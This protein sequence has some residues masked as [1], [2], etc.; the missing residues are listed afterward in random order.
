M[1]CSSSTRARATTSSSSAPRHVQWPRSFRLQCLA[2]GQGHHIFNASPT[3]E[4]KTS[5]MPR[6]R[7]RPRRLQCLANG[8]GQHVRLQCLANGR[9][10]H[11]FNASP[12]V[13]ANMSPMPRQWVKALKNKGSEGARDRRGGAAEES[14]QEQGHRGSQ[15]CPANAA[16]AGE[17][18]ARLHGQQRSRP[19]GR[20]Q[21]EPGLAKEQRPNNDG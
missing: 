16:A 3:V 9:G 17:G 12:T 4:A 10:H 19:G 14:A 7:S 15:R 20:H 1:T 11:I 6:Q 8:R 21:R 2:N 5:P 13:E 18:Q